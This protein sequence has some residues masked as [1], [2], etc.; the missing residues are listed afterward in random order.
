M[1]VDLQKDNSTHGI[2]SNR[3]TRSKRVKGLINHEYCDVCDEGGEL[4]QCEQ[5]PASFHLLCM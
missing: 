2:K 4:V 5:C 3:S 1:L